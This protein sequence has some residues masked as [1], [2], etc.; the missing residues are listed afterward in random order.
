MFRRLVSLALFLLSTG[1][2]AAQ[3]RAE[4]ILDFLSH[5]PMGA[6][7]DTIEIWYG[8][9]IP[10]QPVVLLAEL[11]GAEI[12][13]DMDPFLRTFPRT[14]GEGAASRLDE[15]AATH[16]FDFLAARSYA[17][18]DQRPARA[19]VIDLPPDMAAG[20][21]PV[22][23]ANLGYAEELRAGRPIL[24]RG[25]DFETNFRQRDDVFAYRIGYASRVWIDGGLLVQAGDWG[26]MDRALAAPAGSVGMAPDARAMINILDADLDAPGNVAAIRLYLNLSQQGLGR[27]I[28]VA[29]MVNGMDEGGVFVMIVEDAATAQSMV[30][31][32]E[33]AWTTEPNPAT[34]RPMAE[35]MHGEMTARTMEIEGRSMVVLTVY[36]PHPLEDVPIWQNRLSDRFDIYLMQ[37][38]LA[39]LFD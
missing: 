11:R 15:I 25:E 4:A 17:T 35:M 38:V 6:G 8:T 16:G 36:G 28:M 30:A 32:A 1:P 29:D 21:A 7:E 10:V 2:A 20:V 31:A 5:L 18:M 22:L 12:Q 37:G 3:D 39:W 23:T 13:G 14:L 33:D 9:P 27:A 24:A 19:A 26:T 34:R